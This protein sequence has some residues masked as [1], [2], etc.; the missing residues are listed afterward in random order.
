MT[1]LKTILL[2]SVTGLFLISLGIRSSGLFI[3][4]N[5]TGPTRFDSEV[6][7]E[8]EPFG[9]FNPDTQ[10]TKDLSVVFY[11]SELSCNT[12]VTAELANVAQ[13]YDR[14]SSQVDFYLV[15]QGQDPMYLH[16]L[17]RLG[18]V[19]YPILIE[20]NPGYSGL[21]TTTIALFRKHTNQVLTSIQPTP[22]T[23]NGKETEAF[24]R[25]LKHELG[26]RPVNPKDGKTT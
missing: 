9:L 18:R 12:C 22:E 3:E 7:L 17:R 19:K 5:Q 25:R 8:L 23:V 4:K 2:I 21:T 16:N 14:Y 10:F 1:K 15:V 26:G 6:L 13:W 20:Q 11:F 24:E